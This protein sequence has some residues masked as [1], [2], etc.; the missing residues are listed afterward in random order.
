MNNN[1]MMFYGCHVAELAEKYGTPLYI[2]SEDDIRER[3]REIRTSFVERHAPARAAYASKACQTLELLRIIKE[4]GMS[5]DVVSGGE[6]YAALRAG[7][8]PETMIF[9][10]NSKTEQEVREA[11]EA[12]V[13]TVV[14]DNLSELELLQEVAE[15]TGKIQKVVLRITPGVDSHTHQYISTGQADSKF[16]FSVEEVLEH[17]AAEVL[18]MKNIHFAGVHFH[19]GSQLMENTSHVM[20]V[21]IILDLL[22]KLHDRYGYVAEEINCGGGFGV[23]YAD[24]P[25][26]TKVSDFT[27]PMVE[28]ID[29]FY[30]KIGAPRALITI[31]PGRWIVAEA[32]ITVYEVG[33]VKENAAGRIYAGVDGGFPDNPRTALYEA[34]YEVKAVEK[35]EEACDTKMTIAGKC[36]ESGDIVAFDVMLPPLERGDHIAVLA[37]G[38]YNYAMSSNYNR[39]PRPAMVMVRDGEDRLVVKR[40]TYDDMIRLEL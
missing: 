10:G 29:A 6:I 4:E 8:D 20:A 38:A 2:M 36:C 21:E 32:G 30:E 9:H 27:D 39:L 15:E 22:E 18:S 35:A 11:M 12:G 17:A 1:G 3:C 33:S 13:G 34:R 37:T 25:E 26:R 24:D 16:G 31:E 19:I 7:I 40:E 23:H 5:L 14:V 28:R